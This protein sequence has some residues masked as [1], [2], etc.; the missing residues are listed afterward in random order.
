MPSTCKTSRDRHELIIPRV[1]RK[2]RK[3]QAKD[4]K[5]RMK[6]SRELRHIS[7]TINRPPREVYNFACKARNLPKWATGLGGSIKK[8][9]GQWVADSPMG[10]IKILFA[11]KNTFGVLD[12]DVTLGSGITFHN[13]LRVIPNREASE[14][15]FTLYR[16]P[17]MTNK[18]FL[19][20]TK[21]VR[22]DLKILKGLLEK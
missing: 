6:T 16:Q 19:Q 5:A 1:S 12:H 2:N 10:R 4:R 18:K 9:N 14:I 8:V 3:K 22:K 17:G 7:V 21:W 13:P 11:K 20:D 15:I